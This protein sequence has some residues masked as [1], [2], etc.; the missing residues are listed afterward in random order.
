MTDQ[1]NNTLTLRY[2]LSAL[3]TEQKLRDALIARGWTP[4][5]APSPATVTPAMCQA[6]DRVTLGDRESGPIT[7][8]WDEYTRL[9]CAM[10]AAALAPA[11]CLSAE[12]GSPTCTART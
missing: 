4:P 12:P 10:R 11:A 3:E 2:D 7:L 5:G 9:Y 6:A 1:T 8:S